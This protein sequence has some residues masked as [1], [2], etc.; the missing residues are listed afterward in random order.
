MSSEPSSELYE[1]STVLV[2]TSRWPLVEC[3]PSLDEWLLVE[4]WPLIG[5]RP[6]ADMLVAVVDCFVSMRNV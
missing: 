6:L 4:E 5:G 1:L 3:W 2:S